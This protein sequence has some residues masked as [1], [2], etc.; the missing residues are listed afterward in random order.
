[1]DSWTTFFLP[2]M[3]S[4]ADGF[5][6]ALAQVPEARRDKRPP[7]PLGEWA[8]ARHLFHMVYYEKTYA[9]P[10]MRHWLG[11]P[12]LE[13]PRDEEEETNWHIRLSFPL[14]LNR[15]RENRA[16]QITLLG[17]YSAD[18]WQETRITGWGP[19]NLAWVVSKTYQHT[20]EHTS[21][22]LR[23]VLF[24]DRFAG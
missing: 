13:F 9:L 18:T 12:L 20:A 1:M 2:Q 7:A 5:L 3:Q 22:V 19:V 16:A 17:E 8:V 14:L 6:W 11:Y 23:M 4:G 10:A 24:W 21:D 15:F